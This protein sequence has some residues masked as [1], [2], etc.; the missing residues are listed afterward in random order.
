MARSLSFVSMDG[1]EIEGASPREVMEALRAQEEAAPGD[2]GRY[3]D[4]LQ[5]RGELMLGILLDVGRREETI[6][7]RCRQTVASL[8]RHGWLRVKAAP[9]IPVWPPRPRPR[10]MMPKAEGT[11]A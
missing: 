3:L 2:L 9:A 11:A 8:I 6:D 10:A 4:L 7:A 1:S 5:T